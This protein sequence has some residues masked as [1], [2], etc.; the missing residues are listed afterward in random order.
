M[1][2]QPGTPRFFETAAAF[3]AWL[4]AN[5]ATATELPVGFHEVGSGRP[6]VTWPESVDEAL[7]FGWIDGVR[8]GIDEHAYSIFSTDAWPRSAVASNGRWGATAVMVSPDCM[9]KS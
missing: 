3:R 4:Q 1:S 8:R 9:T 5:A 2:P 6:G 7:C